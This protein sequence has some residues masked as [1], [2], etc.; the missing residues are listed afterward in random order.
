MAT[1]FSAR[2]AAFRPAGGQERP[3]PDLAACSTIRNRIAEKGV[4]P[5]RVAGRAIIYAA[6]RPLILKREG[7]M[8]SFL[9]SSSVAIIRWVARILGTVIG[10][11]ALFGVVEALTY[12]LERTSEITTPGVLVWVGFL[13]IL[14][15]CVVGWFKE[16]AGSLLILG[17]VVLLVAIALL[18]PSEFRNAWILSIPALPGLLYLYV[19][20]ARRKK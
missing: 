18:T 12:H 5:R 10:L 9:G 4:A 3:C 16:L 15:G 1:G 17:G 14:L 11:M 6:L 8:T 7:E 2:R 20:L 13:L 19:G